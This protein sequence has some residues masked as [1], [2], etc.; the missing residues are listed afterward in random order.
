MTYN[1]AVDR[2]MEAKKKIGNTDYLCHKSKSEETKWLLEHKEV[3]KRLDAYRTEHYYTL[4]GIRD[5]EYRLISKESITDEGRIIMQCY[6]LNDKEEGFAYNGSDLE[7]EPIYCNCK[8]GLLDGE[9]IKHYILNDR[10]HILHYVNG[11]KHG[12]SFGFE[13]EGLFTHWV[14]HYGVVIEKKFFKEGEVLDI[15]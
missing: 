9:Y 11:A 10:I 8:N 7:L 2:I 13:K 1:E 4:N 14:Y 15:E 5:G 6:Y 12:D 3:T